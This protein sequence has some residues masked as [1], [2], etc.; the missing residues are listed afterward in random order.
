MQNLN[1][2]NL[3]SMCVEGHCILESLSTTRTANSN[4]KVL[5]DVGQNAIIVGMMEGTQVTEIVLVP[6]WPVYA[7]QAS[8][9]WNYEFW[10]YSNGTGRRCRSGRGTLWC[11]NQCWND[12]VMLWNVLWCLLRIQDCCCI[13]IC[14]VISC[15][16]CH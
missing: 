14:P 16:L 3:S 2:M 8:I 9:S 7:F 11:R 13:L 4:I 10:Y 5:P 15:L 6:T 12:A 1:L